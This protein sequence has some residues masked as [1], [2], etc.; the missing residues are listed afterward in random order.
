MKFEGLDLNDNIMEQYY[1]MIGGKDEHRLKLD[2]LNILGFTFGIDGIEEAVTKH[3]KEACERE[4]LKIFE[5]DIALAHPSETMPVY[6][7]NIR[8]NSLVKLF[9]REVTEDDLPAVEEVVSKLAVAAYQE[10]TKKEIIPSFEDILKI[11]TANDFS[12]QLFE[13]I[14]N[15]MIE[16]IADYKKNKNS[17]HSK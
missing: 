16:E 8:K 4:I 7:L 3:G 1:S 6:G 14:V 17:K 13:D 15:D 5:E 12:K 2:I 11:C 10:S 9:G